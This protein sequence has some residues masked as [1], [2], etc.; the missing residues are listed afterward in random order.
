MNPTAESERR[1]CVIPERMPPTKA[2][3]NAAAFFAGK[4]RLA[5]LGMLVAL[6]A[7]VVAGLAVTLALSSAR[8]KVLFVVLD[9]AGNVIIVPGVTFSEAKELHV[10][11]SMLATSALLLRNPKDFDQPEMLQA[12]FSR[13]AL[14]QAS[15]LKAVEAREFS[16]RQIEQ[17]PQI[18]R[19]DAIVTRQEEIQITVK[20]KV[21]RW[22]VVQQ[23]PFTE[24]IP[25]T[26]GLLL[27]PNPDLLR[28]RRQ[29]TVVTHFNLNYEKS[30]L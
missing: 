3:F 18:T 1:M 5:R 17:K 28:N 15:A 2:P 24:V 6:V 20:G 16:E 11:Q 27:K 26:L 10:Q 23:A 21:T 4:D 8:Q 25:F 30:P 13:S 29:P 12:L 7:L 9:P 22:G 14:A 19:I